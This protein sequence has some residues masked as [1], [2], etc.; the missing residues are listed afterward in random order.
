MK[1]RKKERSSKENTT[2]TFHEK[3][4]F[5]E[6]AEKIFVVRKTFLS[7]GILF[8]SEHAISKNELTFESFKWVWKRKE[9][10]KFLISLVLSWKFE[11]NMKALDEPIFS[12]IATSYRLKLHHRIFIAWFLSWVTISWVDIGKKSLRLLHF[13][14]QRIVESFRRGWKLKNLWDILASFHTN[15]NYVFLNND[16]SFD[17]QQNFFPISS[18]FFFVLS[19]S[20]LLNKNSSTLYEEFSQIFSTM[21]KRR[22][23]LRYEGICQSYLMWICCSYLWA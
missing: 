15:W 23:H 2:K 17:T 20:T 19:P 9:K 22:R 6:N 5:T 14:R 8:E 12:H 10:K 1:E 11:C 4:Y 3:K 7:L 13:Y 21:T 16:P 18:S